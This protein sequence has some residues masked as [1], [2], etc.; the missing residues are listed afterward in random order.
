MIN[1]KQHPIKNSTTTLSRLILTNALTKTLSRFNDLLENGPNSAKVIEL[2]SKISD[3]IEEL[4]TNV[5]ELKALVKQNGDILISDLNTPKEG[6]IAEKIRHSLFNVY[7][8]TSRAIG[9]NTTDAIKE[10]AVARIND[11][12]NKGLIKPYSSK[13]HETP[14]K[15]VIEVISP[16]LDPDMRRYMFETDIYCRP[17]R[18]FYETVKVMRS[19][20]NEGVRRFISTHRNR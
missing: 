10:D 16:K 8:K 20:A 19:R 14:E 12:V 15:F 9:R 6:S 3:F 5:A 4:E 13:C 18:K 17:M 2:N 7:D 1:A 11:L